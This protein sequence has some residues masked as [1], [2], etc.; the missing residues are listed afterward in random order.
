[1]SHVPIGPPMSPPETM[2]TIAEATASVAADGTPA[3]SNSGANASPVAGPPVSV[4]DPASTPSSGGWPSSVAMPEAEH[5]LRDG[6]Q[7][8]GDKEDEDQRS[9]DAQQR[10]ARAK[11]DGREKRVL[12]RRLQR[13]VEGDRRE[14]ALVR[15]AQDGGHE[16]AADD[17]RR[18]VVPAE[19]RD[20]PLDAVADEEHDTGQ[21][22]GLNQIEREQTASCPCI[23][24]GARANPI[25]KGL[26]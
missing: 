1:M 14:P 10:Q 24:P 19:Q 25:R 13:R 20:P 16:Q 22:E 4:T 26:E 18:D 9:A 6:G 2:P 21:R 8:G 23:V 3:S 15:D 7:R 11:A 17:R 5:V 12:Q